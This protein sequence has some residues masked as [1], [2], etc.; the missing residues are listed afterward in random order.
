MGKPRVVIIG[1]GFGGLACAQYLK[2]ADVDVTLIDRR[3]FHLFQPLLY[4]V[5][6]GGLSPANIASPLRCILRH[7][8]NAKI[9]MEEVTGV[10]SVDK[11]VSFKSGNS[12]AYDFLIVAAGSISH[13]FGRDQEWSERASG[14]KTIE[15][16]T[17]IR[18]QVLGVFEKAEITTDLE[19]RKRLLTFVIVGGG[20][21]GIELAGAICELAH[22]TMRHEFRNIDP[23]KARVI[24]VEFSPVVL[25][26]YHPSLSA[27][28]KQALL[29]LGAEV[30]NES[31]LTEIGDG[32]V[33]ILKKGTTERVLTSTVL[34]AAGVK[35]SPLGARLAECFDKVELDRSGRVMVNEY[36]QLPGHDSVYV[37]G[38]LA[39]FRGTNGSPLPGVAPV[40]IQQ[41]EYVGKQIKQRIAGKKELRPFAYWDKGNM[42][43]IGRSRAVMESGKIRSSGRIAWLAWLF[44]HILYLARFE[45]RVMV[46]FQWAWNYITRNRT[47]RLITEPN[48]RT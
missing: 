48:E 27:K 20:P 36:C 25:E 39:H 44:I 42:A 14:L 19:E 4:Q 13:Y 35:A 17:Q 2:R 46:L 9:L 7:Q 11:V 6:T 37:V 40:A 1:G 3:N 34:W 16:A 15:D 23:S 5:A 18:R 38:D 28:A 30:W 26:R 47:A 10:N 31:K 45:N 32:Y 8:R 41:G 22:Q 29:D 33:E 12:V 24:L 21:T 43:T